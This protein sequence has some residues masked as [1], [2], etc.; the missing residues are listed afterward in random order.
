VS[1]VL[2]APSEENCNMF[3]SLTPAAFYGF[4][5][6]G[7]CRIEG[8]EIFTCGL[9]D[10]S[11][12]LEIS[13]VGSS[14]PPLRKLLGCDPCLKG[15]SR[16][17]IP[18]DKTWNCLSCA[19]EQYVIDPNNPLFQCQPCPQGA[20]CNGNDLVGLVSGS[21]WVPDLMLGIYR[22]AYCPEVL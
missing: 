21:V 22:L 2:C 18:L 19:S 17:D 6:H 4:D 9:N 15:E 3:S 8:K 12:A 14:F 16:K 10:T 20:M 13:I 7:F 11:V 5:L 1:A